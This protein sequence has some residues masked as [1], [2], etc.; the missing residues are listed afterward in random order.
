MISSKL[1]LRGDDDDLGKIIDNYNGGD[2]DE[3]I[4]QMIEDY[5]SKGPKTLS[6]PS[7]IIL[8]KF[9]SGSAVRHFAQ[10]ALGLSGENLEKFMQEEYNEAWSKYDV[11]KEGQIPETMLPLFFKSLVGD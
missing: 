1:R 10:S 9:N 7:G 11:N 6:N 4:K 5:G 3:F 8:T 2:N